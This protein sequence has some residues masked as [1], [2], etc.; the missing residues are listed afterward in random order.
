MTCGQRTASAQVT[1]RFERAGVGASMTR[2][3]HRIGLPLLLAAGAL[4]FPARRRETA[5]IMIGG[6][7]LVFGHVLNWRLRHRHG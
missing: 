5:G 6:V 3:I 7:W 4:L 1:G 2:L